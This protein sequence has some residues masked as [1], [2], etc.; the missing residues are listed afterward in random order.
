MR[1]PSPRDKRAMGRMTDWG[2]WEKG[3]RNQEAC[4]KRKSLRLTLGKGD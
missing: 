2:D 3:M 4:V 1:K